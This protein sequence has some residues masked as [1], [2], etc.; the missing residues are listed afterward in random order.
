MTT[1]LTDTFYL[2]RAGRYAAPLNSAD[3]L[4]VVYGDLTDGTLGVWTLPEIDT[5]NYVFAFAGHEVLSVANGNSISIYEND[6]LLDPAMYTFNEANNYEG[7]GVIATID[8]T[9]PKTGSVITARGMG[10]PTTSGGA[11]LMENIVDI[12]YDLMT[13]ENDWTAANFEG[14]AKARA[15]QLFT[16][17]S[18]KAAGVIAEDAVLWNIVTDMLSSFLGSAWLDGNGKL[19]LDIDTNTIAYEYGQNA[20]F[21]R[22]DAELTDAIQRLA[23]I[24]NQCPCNYSYNYV[25]GEFKKQTNDT[26]HADAISQGIYG[27][28][29]PNTPYQFYWCRDLTSVQTVQDLIVAKFKDPLYEITIQDASP[30]HYDVDVGAI[31]IFSAESLYGK[32]GNPLRNHFWRVLSVQPDLQSM[33]AKVRTLQT[34]Y[35][36]TAGYLADGTYLADGSIFAGSNRDMTIF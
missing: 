24:I 3:R 5:A 14:T 15:A 27:V 19:V 8:F 9:T 21:S 10:K 34:E 28:R 12:I 33:T 29:E 22:A 18:Y 7:L 23:N 20:I 6:L 13:V 4:P 30:K 26:A 32:D 16:A 31:I 11:T 36:L 1:K 25:A 2:K 35:Y 17:Q